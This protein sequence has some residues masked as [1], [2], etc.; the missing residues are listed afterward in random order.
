MQVNEKKAITE[1][2]RALDTEKVKLDA[3]AQKQRDELITLLNEELAPIKKELDPLKKQI[4]KLDKEKQ[5][6]KFKL[7]MSR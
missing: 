4:Q 6:I 1:E 2:I 7:T 3:I 5:S